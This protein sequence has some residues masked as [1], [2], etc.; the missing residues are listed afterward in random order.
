MWS[1]LRQM[2]G[3]TLTPTLLL[4]GEGNAEAAIVAAKLFRGTAN[5]IHAYNPAPRMRFAAAIR[6][7]SKEIA[8]GKGTA[9]SRCPFDF[10]RDVLAWRR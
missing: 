3:G 7:P 6:R 9:H 5:K 2:D 8:P 4:C 1:K 10:L